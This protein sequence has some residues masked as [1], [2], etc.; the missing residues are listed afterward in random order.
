M[1]AQRIVAG[2]YHDK[3][4]DV[5]LNPPSRDDAAPNSG[6]AY[7]FEKRDGD[8]TQTAY[9]KA[10]NPD[11]GDSFGSSVAVSGSTVVVG[12]PWEQSAARG[13]DAANGEDLDQSD[14]EAM[15]S[16]AAYVFELD[17]ENDAWSQVA[18]LKAHNAG[19]QLRFGN[20]VSADAQTIAVGAFTETSGATGIDPDQDDS[21]APEAG[22]VYIFDDTDDGWEQSAYIKA[23]NTGEGDRFGGSLVLR[24]NALAV[25]ASLESSAETGAA[26]STTLGAQ[27]NDDA[28]GAGA[29]YVYYRHEETWTQH[30]YLKAS[31]AQPGDNFGFSLGFDGTTLSVGAPYEDSAIGG[32][33]D[34]GGGPNNVG[35]SSGAVYWF[36]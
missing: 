27:A 18:Y 32:V 34:E 7:V 36:R 6:A 29:V 20:A 13:G 30:A 8:W 22:A 10:S 12:S 24:S 11:P 21:S 31:N 25:G 14:N 16:G 15:F 26:A 5:G 17:D 28:L 3:S 35:T 9:F 1:A 2:A 4:S 33:S 23:S 19:E